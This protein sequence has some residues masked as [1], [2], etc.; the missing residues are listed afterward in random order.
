MPAAVL[1]FPMQDQ[2]CS[3]LICHL[4]QDGNDF[5]QLGETL[6]KQADRM[7]WLPLS[8][9][10]DVSARFRMTLASDGFIIT[11]FSRS[12]GELVGFG[13]A[14]LADTRRDEGND[15][16]LLDLPYEG[17]PVALR[18]RFNKGDSHFWVLR[19][20]VSLH[21]RVGVGTAILATI[22]QRLRRT[23]QPA[24]LLARTDCRYWSHSEHW[25]QNRGFSKIAS[26]FNH[27]A[28]FERDLSP[29]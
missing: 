17:L 11:A 1:S 7:R 6:K 16:R 22:I 27:D 12:N 24:V 8:G 19:D 4:A 9:A 25:L 13:G 3:V 29:I 21:E 18:Q 10:D 5:T 28:V 2:P 20:L 23:S 26:T 15:W 14:A